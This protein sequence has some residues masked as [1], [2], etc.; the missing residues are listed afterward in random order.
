M[1]GH[2]GRRQ[3][4]SGWY[5][6]PIESMGACRRPSPRH[7]RH[8]LM[9]LD[10]TQWTLWSVIT[11]RS[12]RHAR[13]PTEVN[14]LSLNATLHN[15]P[16]GREHPRARYPQEHHTPVPTGNAVRLAASQDVL[17][18]PLGVRPYQGSQLPPRDHRGRS[19][20]GNGSPGRLIFSLIRMRSSPFSGVRIS[21]APQATD[22]SVIWRTIIP[23]L[24]NRKVSSSTTAR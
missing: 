1:N 14:E 10:S 22:V 9:D 8:A 3:C 23:S 2:A 18:Q 7:P 16:T 13:W 6:V 12:A 19:R 5:V 24:E 17:M 21:A 20:R 4:W 11:T 15:G